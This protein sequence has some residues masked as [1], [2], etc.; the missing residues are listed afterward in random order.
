MQT[1]ANV[2]LK[3]IIVEFINIFQQYFIEIVHV[4]ALVLEWHQT[5]AKLLKKSSWASDVVDLSNSQCFLYALNNFNL[6]YHSNGVTIL[7]K[8]SN[9]KFKL[10]CSRLVSCRL[11]LSIGRCSFTRAW[12]C[13]ALVKPYACPWFNLYVNHRLSWGEFPS[14]LQPLFIRQLIPFRVC[15]S[16]NSRSLYTVWDYVIASTPPYL[17]VDRWWRT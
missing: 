14:L 1:K 7:L 10:A 12:L 13:L 16:I 17:Y 5:N 11:R 6:C 3:I 15:C 2:S 9:G 8:L 4:L